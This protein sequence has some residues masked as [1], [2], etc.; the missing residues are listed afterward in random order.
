[1]I[2]IIF[3]IILVLSLIGLGVILFR[4]MPDLVNLP[5]QPLALQKTVVLNIKR[6]VKKLPVL[7]SFSYEI[8]LQRILSRVRVLTLKTDHKTSSW[9]ERLRKKQS[10]E[11]GSNN[12]K[13][14]EE[15]KKA[16]DGR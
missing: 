10:Q 15:L 16:K 11:N 6:G 4:R 2:E 5:E 14:W 7:K 8:Y 13:Y 9:L 12:D 3:T 1:M